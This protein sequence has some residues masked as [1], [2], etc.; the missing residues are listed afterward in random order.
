MHDVVVVQLL[1]AH[2]QDHMLELLCSRALATKQGRHVLDLEFVILNRPAILALGKGHDDAHVCNTC[3][4]KMST[5]YE[6]HDDRDWGGHG[7][8]S[9]HDRDMGMMLILTMTPPS[10]TM[11]I[12]HNVNCSSL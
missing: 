1:H 2:G 9:Q 6:G 7:D 3:R 10:M 4:G 8:A 11:T 5:N 12:T